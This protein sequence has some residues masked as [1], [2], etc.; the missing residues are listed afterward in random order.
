MSHYY[1]E[2][3]FGMSL[4]GIL[5]ST[6]STYRSMH[7]RWAIKRRGINGVYRAI[8]NE[9]MLVSLTF[10]ILQALF[11]YASINM[12]QRDVDP[13]TPTMLLASLLLVGMIVFS[14]QTRLYLERTLEK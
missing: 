3:Q 12:M 14:W 9:R 5:I 6:Y 2:I 13:Q 4:I 8:A 11:F 7:N 10:W 1:S